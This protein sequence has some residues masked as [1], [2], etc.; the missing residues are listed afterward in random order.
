[1]RKFENLGRM[2][3]KDEQRR[4][5]GGNPPEEGGGVCK[6]SATACTYMS[7]SGQAHTG[8]CGDTVAG[9]MGTTL[10]ACKWQ[11]LTVADTNCNIAQ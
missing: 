5:R 8:T 2:L 11:G 6:T 10:C 1:M 4:I 3:S 7:P 9:P